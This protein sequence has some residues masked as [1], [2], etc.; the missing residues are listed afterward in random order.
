MKN[1]SDKRGG[2]VY[3]RNIAKMD[4][5]L[6]HEIYRKTLS[7]WRYWRLV[8]GADNPLGVNPLF[9]LFV[10]RRPLNSLGG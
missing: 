8:V 10:A 7:W 5:G 2:M 9:I 4:M 3:V 6:S 1:Q